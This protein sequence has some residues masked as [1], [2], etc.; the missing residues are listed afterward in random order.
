MVSIINGAG[1]LEVPLF[2]LRAMSESEE[3]EVTCRC[4]HH[5]TGNV[6]RHVGTVF[7]LISGAVREMKANSSCWCGIFA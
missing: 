7:G 6:G 1:G 3:V 4:A 2:S 5:H